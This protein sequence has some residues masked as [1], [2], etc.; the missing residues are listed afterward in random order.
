MPF[1][2]WFLGADLFRDKTSDLRNQTLKVVVFSH[3]PAV[4]KIPAPRSKTVRTL[5]GYG[6]LRFSGL[7][8]E[9]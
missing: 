5:L 3:I 9:V 4:T 7:E 8:V 1:K 6:P 2:Y